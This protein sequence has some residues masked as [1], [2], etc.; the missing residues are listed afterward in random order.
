GL[1]YVWNK[2][3]FIRGGYKFN[4]DEQDYSFG[5]GLNVPISIAE[6]TLDYSFSNFQRLGSAHRFSIILGF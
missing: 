6:F 1:E 4:V 2:I 5:A 3:L